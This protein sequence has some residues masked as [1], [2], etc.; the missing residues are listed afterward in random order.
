MTKQTT[1]H[2]EQEEWIE[3]LITMGASDSV[4]DMVKALLATERA[5]AVIEHDAKWHPMKKIN[6]E[7]KLLTHKEVIS[8]HLPNK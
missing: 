5:K 3:D 8:K 7:W 4:I 2:P 6:D 1:E